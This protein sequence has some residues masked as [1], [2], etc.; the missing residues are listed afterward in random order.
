MPKERPRRWP[1]GHRA[2]R[3]SRR[4]APWSTWPGTARL[5]LMSPESCG[6]WPTRHWMKPGRTRPGGSVRRWRHEAVRRCRQPAAAS[7]TDARTRGWCSVGQRSRT[8]SCPASSAYSSQ[9][10]SRR[11]YSTVFADELTAPS[12]HLRVYGSG[13]VARRTAVRFTRL[14]QQPGLVQA[15][16]QALGLAAGQAGVRRSVENGRHVVIHAAAL[17]LSGTA[18]PFYEVGRG[19]PRHLV[20]ASMVAGM[21]A[22]GGSPRRPGATYSRYPRCQPSRPV[23]YSRVRCVP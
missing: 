16:S 22:S 20:H 18:D 2:A 17:P 8:C 10:E 6:A 5:G 14:G 11:T 15:F 4:T 1:L 3:D 21:H 12:L 23:T 19:S 13:L 9:R 7:A